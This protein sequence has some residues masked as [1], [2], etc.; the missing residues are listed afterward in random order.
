M[1]HEGWLK[2][3]KSFED[4]LAALPAAERRAV[5]QR[6][7]VVLAEE[8]TLRE[9]RKAMGKT[10][11]EM[12]RLLDKPQASISRMETQA[13]MLIS[14]LGEVIERLGG[15]LSLRAELPGHAPVA[16]SG[17]GDIAPARR[18]VGAKAARKTR[19]TRNR[20][21]A[22]TSGLKAAQTSPR[23]ERARADRVRERHE[24]AAAAHAAATTGSNH[25]DD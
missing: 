3:G 7:Q 14:T 25:A 2:M 11:I 12:A 13:D 15:R 9:L 5:E 6:P 18:L 4:V 20:V 17:L 1:A 8:M 24:T 23:H 22:M 19:A 21:L 16:I 10:Q